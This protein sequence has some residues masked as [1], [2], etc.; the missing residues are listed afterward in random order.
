MRRLKWVQNLGWMA[1]AR[2]VSM[3]PMV[4]VIAPAPPPHGNCNITIAQ[5]RL[6]VAGK[7]GIGGVP[8]D[9]G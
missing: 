2:R 6:M 5:H 7:V 3:L 9:R 1:K 4:P 8:H